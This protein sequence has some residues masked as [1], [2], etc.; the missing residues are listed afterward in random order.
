MLILSAT[1]SNDLTRFRFL[2]TH[3]KIVHFTEYLIFGFLM[4]NAVNL[5]INGNKRLVLVFGA[6]VFFPIL[7]E[8][9]QNFTPGRFPDVM[10][11]IVDICGGILGALTRY[12]K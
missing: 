4:M 9:L 3:D 2:A 8:S 7:D 12:R 11:G 6:L 1:P 10:D 5:N